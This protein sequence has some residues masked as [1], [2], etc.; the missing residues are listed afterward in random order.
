MDLPIR[1]RRPEDGWIENDGKM[2][3]LPHML[4]DVV[5]DRDF[6]RA[7]CGKPAGRF[8]WLVDG[9]HWNVTHWRLHEELVPA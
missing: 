1:P 5:I 8:I 3:V 7:I 4:V 2:P 9:S 6:D